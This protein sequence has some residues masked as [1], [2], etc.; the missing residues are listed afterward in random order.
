MF[1]LSL[2]ISFT[3][4]NRGNK[5]TNKKANNN[6]IKLKNLINSYIKIKFK[7]FGSKVSTV[8]NFK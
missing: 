1:F 4:I 6:A 2:L 7:F 5:K 8:S 3:I